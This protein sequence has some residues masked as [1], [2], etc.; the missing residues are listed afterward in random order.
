MT[1][2][3][4]WGSVTSMLSGQP[5][6]LNSNLWVQR[7]GIARI[8]ASLKPKRCV[9]RVSLSPPSK[10]LSLCSKTATV[11]VVRVLLSR[12]WQFAWLPCFKRN[13]RSNLLPMSQFHHQSWYCANCLTFVPLSERQEIWP[14]SYF[15]QLAT[16]SLTCFGCS[17]YFY[18]TYKSSWNMV[19][20]VA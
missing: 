16:S 10:H 11:D 12:S 9:T 17:L 20:Q 2:D 5:N 1:V 18:L 14:E 15:Y 19:Q 4:W 8:Q 7:T 3:G 6:T 13:W